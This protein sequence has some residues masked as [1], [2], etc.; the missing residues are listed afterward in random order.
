MPVSVQHHALSKGRELTTLL[1]LCAVQFTHIL[2]FMIMMPLGAQLMR[3]FAI[4]PAEFTR[5]VAAYGL[6]AAISGFTRSMGTDGSG[7]ARRPGAASGSGYPR[8][9]KQQNGAPRLYRRHRVP[10]II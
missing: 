5:L 6:A 7:R 1:V 10:S 2:D 3:V 8:A 4:S 9:T